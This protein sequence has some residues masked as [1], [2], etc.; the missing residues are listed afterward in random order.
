MLSEDV[1]SQD[2]LRQISYKPPSSLEKELPN[3]KIIADIVVACD[4]AVL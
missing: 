1:S 2:M 4:D 3:P